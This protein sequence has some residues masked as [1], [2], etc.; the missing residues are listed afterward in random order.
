MRVYQSGNFW[1]HH[2]KY[3]RPLKQIPVN[4]EF[5]WEGT[6]GRIP[7]IY[8]GTEGMVIDLCICIPEEKIKAYM[9]KWQEKSESGALSEEEEELIIRENPFLVEFSL[10][11]T[12]NGKELQHSGGCGCCWNPVLMRQQANLKAADRYRKE[13]APARET[14][15]IPKKRE[16]TVLEEELADTYNCD[17]SYGWYFHRFTYRWPG[18]EVSYEKRE[19]GIIEEKR[20]R[21]TRIK[22]MERLLLQFHAKKQPVSAEHF[23][24]ETM[25]SESFAVTWGDLRQTVKNHMGYGIGMKHPLTGEKVVLTIYD[26][27]DEKLP[28]DSFA[29]AKSR[30]MEYPTNYQILSYSIYPELPADAFRLEDCGRGDAPK[31][32]TENFRAGKKAAASAAVIGGADGPTAVFM[33][34]KSRVPDKHTVCSSLHFERVQKVEWKPVF[35]VAQREDMTLTVKLQRDVES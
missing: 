14:D 7:A 3:E 11:V 12:V 31:R 24:T 35:L 29:S 30:E 21:G 1:G 5:V 8:T 26:C 13:H 15:F 4:Q 10:D 9:D 22:N 23:V 28:E 2:R 16:H 18:V 25:D 17:K 34:G 19:N 33:A 27:E 6:N 32:K 20:T